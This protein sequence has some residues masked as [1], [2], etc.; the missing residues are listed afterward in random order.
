MQMRAAQI[1]EYGDASVVHVN[2]IDVPSIS[3]GKVLVKVHAASLNPFDTKIREGYM[4]EM[5][6]LQFPTTLGGDIA[7]IVTEISEGVTNVAVGDKVYGQ[8]NAVAGNSGAIA[9]YAA[10]SAGEVAKIPEG[11]DFNEAASLALAGVSAVQAINHHTK[12][13]PGQKLFINGGA[14]AI[15]A[16][17]IQIAKGLGAY[18]AVTAT[19]ESVEFVKQLGADE[20]VDYK[21]TDFTEVLSNYDAVFDTVGG[22]D[23]TKSLAI[24]KQGGIAISMAAQADEARV[25]ELSVTAISQQTR[26]T[27]EL[28][29]ELS[30]LIEAGTVRALVDKVFPLD[31]IKEAFEAREAGDVRT[32]IVIEIK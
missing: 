28:L 17:A 24:L 2:E 19:G 29:D 20:V 27:T 8:A 1:N 11:T 3:D 12:L 9:E 23:F 32:K 26:V 30:Q 13:Q 21:T 5:I 4:K 6:P 31:Q 10:T 22:E 7:G 16:N 15:G 18:V 14:G 25:K